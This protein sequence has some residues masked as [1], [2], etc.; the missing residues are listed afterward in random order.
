MAGDFSIIA[1][2]FK[3]SFL[4][5]VVML[6]LLFSSVLSW[7]I[8]FNRNKLLIH[9]IKIFE[10]FQSLFNSG[11]ELLSIYKKISAQ[12]HK[13]GV[14]LIFFKG[15]NE[16]LNLSKNNEFR[17]ELIVQEVKRTMEVALYKENETLEKHLGALATIQSIAPYVGLFGTIWGIMNVFHQL[18]VSA[19]QATLSVVAPGISEALIATAMG[20]VTAIPAGIFYNKFIGR[21]DVLMGGYERSVQELL[22]IIGKR[23]Y[24]RQQQI[25]PTQHSQYR[26]GQEG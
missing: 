12:K 15:I 23:I 21:I 8:I 9:R 19:S 22:G 16:F 1:M 17:P 3:A 13:D 14:E 7:G 6:G 11:V 5:K 24:Y 4:V 20:L 2:F 25:N 10:K 26:S 18:G